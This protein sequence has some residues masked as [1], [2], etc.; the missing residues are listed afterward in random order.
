MSWQFR[1]NLFHG[2]LRTFRNGSDIIQSRLTLPTATGHHRN[3]S[4]SSL[5]FVFS[6]APIL[7][8]DIT[9]VEMRS[10]KIGK[11][12]AV[13]KIVVKSR[14]VR[15]Q[16]EDVRTIYRRYSDFYTL[17][18]KISNKFPE[19]AK[20]EFPSKKTFGN[21][22]S[23]VLEKRQ[24]MLRTYLQVTVQFVQVKLF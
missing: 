15:G 7:Q 10:E 16:V 19:L 18:E 8:A 20:L 24:K 22:Q 17:H 23:Q 9:D 2:C 5:D 6:N 11:P 21:T 3:A 12:Y 4:Q 1:K 14:D 13:Y